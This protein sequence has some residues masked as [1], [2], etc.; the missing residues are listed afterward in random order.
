MLSA[1]PMAS[2]QATVLGRHATFRNKSCMTTGSGTKN[3]LRKKLRPYL[4]DSS[5]YGPADPK[6][7]RFEKK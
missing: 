7:P 6:F 5:V 3:I 4:F 1:W 2:V